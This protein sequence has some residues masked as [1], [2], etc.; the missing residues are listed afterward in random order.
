MGL[1]F[2]FT[3][4]L[5]KKVMALQTFPTQHHNDKFW[6]LIKIWSSFQFRQMCFHMEISRIHHKTYCLLIRVTLV[7]ACRVLGGDRDLQVVLFHSKTTCSLS[8]DDKLRWWG[9]SN[10][11]HINLIYWNIRKVV[12]AKTFSKVFSC[13]DEMA[14]TKMRQ[15]VPGWDN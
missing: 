8:G 1:L 5:G 3:K 9:H 7:V 10:P 6:V 15:L 14:S 2:R 13:L 4:L 11:T 12:G